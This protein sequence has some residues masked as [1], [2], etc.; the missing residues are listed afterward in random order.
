MYVLTVQSWPV[1]H[2]DYI[3]ADTLSI[4]IQIDGVLLG[5]VPMPAAEAV[6]KD[7]IESFVAATALYK[8][9]LQRCFVSMTACVECSPNVTRR[10]K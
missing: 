3:V 9:G 10:K 2:A 7:A 1:Y 4:T 8:V 6:D 5:V